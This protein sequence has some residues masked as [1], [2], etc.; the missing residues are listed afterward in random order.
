MKINLKNEELIQQILYALL[1]LTF[2]ATLFASANA[3]SADNVVVVGGKD[4][5]T[6]S[7]EISSIEMDG[8][9][10]KHDNGVTLVSLKD[11]E[12]K[13]KDAL[14]AAGIIK[15][16]NKVVVNGKLD[17][18]SFNNPVIVAD[19]I[20]VEQTATP[21]AVQVVPTPVQPVPVLPTPVTPA[22]TVTVVPPAE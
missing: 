8:F 12:K 2:I 14:Q 16:G 6:M 4:Q 22:P 7:G 17:K 3:R 21:P 19:N 18:G 15:A 11:I 10:L 1:G 13:D 9:V 20:V 5:V